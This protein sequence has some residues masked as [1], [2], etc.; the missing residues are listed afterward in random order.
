MPPAFQSEGS[1][2]IWQQKRTELRHR[3]TEDKGK[4]GSWFHFSIPVT[5]LAEQ[6]NQALPK[7]VHQPP[8]L[9]SPAGANVPISIQAGRCPRG[10]CW[11]LSG[12]CLPPL[13]PPKPLISFLDNL[14]MMVTMMH[15]HEHH[16]ISILVMRPIP[17]NV[18]GV[19]GLA[20]YIL[21]C[22]SPSLSLDSSLYL[23]P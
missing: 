17:R 19:K 15:F 18:F 16:L 8:A 21:K 23:F 12:V 5:L 7:L 14:E 1:K 9:S 22:C 10:S 3:T 20:R 11:L 2:V 4:G 13:L 6:G